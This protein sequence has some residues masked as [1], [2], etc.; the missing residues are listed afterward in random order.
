[1]PL[2]QAQLAS[3]VADRADLTTADLSV[4]GQYIYCPIRT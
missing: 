3:A 4:I 1:M 2:T